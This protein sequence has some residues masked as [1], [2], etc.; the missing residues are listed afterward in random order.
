MSEDSDL[1]KKLEKLTACFEKGGDAQETLFA[2][3]AAITSLLEGIQR[4]ERKELVALR[5]FRR[6][7]DACVRY[8]AD[9]TEKDYA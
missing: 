9:R 2:A 5:S 1:P 3:A 7:D 4:A 6:I 8:G